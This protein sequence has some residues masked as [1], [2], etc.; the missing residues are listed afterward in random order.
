MHCLIG[1]KNDSRD[2]GRKKEINP[3]KTA[4][5]D[6]AKNKSLNLLP[7]YSF[8]LEYSPFEPRLSTTA[9]ASE[10]EQSFVESWQL[11]L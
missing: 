3:Q 6:D 8:V 11:R 1:H 10:G 7:R 4:R 2:M 5:G 9:T